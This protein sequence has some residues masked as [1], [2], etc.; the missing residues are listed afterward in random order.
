MTGRQELVLLVLGTHELHGRGQAGVAVGVAGQAEVDWVAIL[1]DDGDIT[2]SGV[3][4]SRR[5][6]GHNTDED[7]AQNQRLN[8]S[9]IK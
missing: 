8:L 9:N 4:D 5:D 3:E 1:V 7:I 2:T 6:D